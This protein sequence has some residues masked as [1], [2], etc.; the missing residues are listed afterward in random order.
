MYYVVSGLIRS[1][2]G[3]ILLADNTVVPWSDVYH[4]NLSEQVTYTSRMLVN[5]SSTVTPVEMYIQEKGSTPRRNLTSIHTVSNGHMT[6]TIHDSP[7]LSI[8]I[9]KP[10]DFELRPSSDDNDR[11]LIGSVV[12]AVG[13]DPITRNVT[14]NVTCTYMNE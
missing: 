12:R 11:V 9:S 2:E 10:F 1:V 6:M 14:M 7:T 3:S 8:V 4:F 13:G 5:F